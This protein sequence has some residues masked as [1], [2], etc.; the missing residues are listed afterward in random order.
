MSTIDPKDQRIA[1]LE[2]QVELL[3]KKLDMA[4]QVIAHQ[5]K[6]I[7]DLEARLGLNSSNSS[8][9]PS[10]DPPSSSRPSKPPSGKK[11]GG[12]R[13]HQRSIR[14]LVAPDFI[15]E[16]KPPRCKSCQRALNGD[17]PA[18]IRHQ[19]TEIPRIRPTVTEYR[20]HEL[21]C[22]CGKLTRAPL[23][24]GVPSGAFGPVLMSTVALFT[25]R[26]RQSKRLAQE[27]LATFLNVD[28]SHGAICKIE[29][30]TS[31]A[32]AA[33]VEEA[34]LFVQQQPVV[35]GDETGWP[36]GK[37]DGRK[38]MAWLWVATTPLVTV[39]LIA[40]SRGEA[41]A[42]KLLGDKFNGIFGS[43]RWKAYDWLNAVMRQLCWA[44]LIR[45]FQS[46]VD[47]KGS[48][49]WVGEALL[50]QVEKM[51]E[52]WAKLNAQQLTREQFQ[53]QMEPVR[54]EILRLLKVARDGEDKKPA[55]MAKAMLKLEHGLFTFVDEEGVEPTNN[56]SE[57]A[58]RPGVIQKK[59]T[60]GTESEKG[61][62][63]VERMLTVTTTLRQ[64]N[65]DVLGFLISAHEA[66][67]KGALADSLLPA[68]P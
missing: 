48:S 45:D 53:E 1:E 10:S 36:E 27:F 35:N 7:E 56:A 3:T 46:W 15:H 63:F 9:P 54:E 37:A 55:G 17:D 33:P 61:S 65:R 62:R 26:Y 49:A 24:E 67:I 51:F 58:L 6:R 47:R 31:S 13:G 68:T 43:D 57:R 25:T 59:L 40:R 60:F 16:L 12:Q 30:R 29:Q 19:V 28:I 38:L 32:I 4:L 20:L 22:P 66:Q 18:P 52:W 8:K 14:P 64:Q 23:P 2:A 5:A 44:H 42:K 11:P 34:R 39:F 41:I 50:V 21:S